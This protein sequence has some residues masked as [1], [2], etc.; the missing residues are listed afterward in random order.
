[1]SG[2]GDRW[3]LVVGGCGVDVVGAWPS[4][5]LIKSPIKPP[6]RHRACRRSEQEPI[7][8]RSHGQ[9]SAAGMPACRVISMP[10]QP[11]QSCA[12]GAVDGFVDGASLGPNAPV[13]KWKLA[14][15]AGRHCLP[16]HWRKDNLRRR[17]ASR[18]CTAC[19]RPWRPG[20]PTGTGL[21]TPPGRRSGSIPPAAKRMGCL[22]FA[23][24]CANEYR[25][26]PTPLCQL[27]KSGRARGRGGGGGERGS[28]Y[29][30]CRK[31][32]RTPFQI[33]T[34][35]R[36]K[37]PL[38]LP[39]WVFTLGPVPTIVTTA[40]TRQSILYVDERPE[41]AFSA[42]FFR[43]ATFCCAVRVRFPPLPRLPGPPTVS[44]RVWPG[45]S[46]LCRPRN[47]R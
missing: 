43:L 38:S 19:Q 27:D 18:R 31:G 41:E 39:Y 8:R 47:R 45:T 13:D 26:E 12:G 46:P 5:R 28:H 40:A 4:S 11:A 33:P 34:P 24:H 1:M 25:P 44:L 21:S 35:S 30:S 42:V 17:P 7:A 23:N 14:R 36:V 6:D 15:R 10:W 20:C 9:T 29:V 22:S 37:S 2:D 32:T 3:M 16:H